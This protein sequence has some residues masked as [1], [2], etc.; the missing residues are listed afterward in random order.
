LGSPGDIGD[1]RPDQIRIFDADGD[2]TLIVAS[3]N[4]DDD[5]P[6]QSFD[7]SIGFND[8]RQIVFIATLSSGQRG[9]FRCDDRTTE[10]IAIEGTDKFHKLSVSHRD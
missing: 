5:S 3:Q 9:I 7:N 1:E 10:L 4:Y 2:S 8:N 6:Y